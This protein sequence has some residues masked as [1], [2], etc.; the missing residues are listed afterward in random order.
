MAFGE[1]TYFEH[2]HYFY[3]MVLT[4]ISLK[5]GAFNVSKVDKLYV[6]NHIH[7]VLVYFKINL[8]PNHIFPLSLNEVSVHTEFAVSS[9]LHLLLDHD[10]LLFTS[11][12]STYKTKYNN[13]FCFFYCC[14]LL[15]LNRHAWRIGMEICR[16]IT[17]VLDVVTYRRL[18]NHIS[19]ELQRDRTGTRITL[20][21]VC[22]FFF[23]FFKFWGSKHF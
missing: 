16:V 11:R 10:I 19:H 13:I 9:Y 22:G 8:R 20:N 5:K 17:N 12:K 14:C 2:N 4:F 6:L 7:H 3:Y 18:E 1:L 23:K 15:S 21:K